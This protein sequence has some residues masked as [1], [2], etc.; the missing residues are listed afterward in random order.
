V[1]LVVESPFDVERHVD[2]RGGSQHA[3]ERSRRHLVVVE[4]APLGKGKGKGRVSRREEKQGVLLVLAPAR[5]VLV[6]EEV[7]P[8]DGV[9]QGRLK[10][11]VDEAHLGEV[12]QP[13]FV[14]AGER[15]DVVV[16]A[17]LP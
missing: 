12:E 7:V 17:W 11:C 4:A 1:R 9:V 14:L 8:P 5:V 10:R 16:L 2:R 3:R 6:P 13:A 15:G